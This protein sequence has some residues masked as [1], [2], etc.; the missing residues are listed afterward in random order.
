[1]KIIIRQQIIP[2]TAYHKLAAKS[3]DGQKPSQAFQQCAG[4]GKTQSK[5]LAIPIWQR[6]H[7]ALSKKQVPSK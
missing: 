3:L 1:M 5:Q 4:V 2:F 7:K 6:Q